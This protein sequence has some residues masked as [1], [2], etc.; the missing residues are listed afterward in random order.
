MID[1]LIKKEFLAHKEALEKS[2]E[3]L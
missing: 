1:G 2:L 3:S